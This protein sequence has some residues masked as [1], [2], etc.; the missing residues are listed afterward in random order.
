MIK[1]RKITSGQSMFEVVLALFIITMIII[2]VVILSTSSVSNALSSRR[3]TQAVKYTQEAI[4]W[5]R[6]EKIADISQFMVY[7]N[8]TSYC[9]NS[10]PP[11]FSNTGTCQSSELIESTFKRDLSFSK[12]TI[13]VSGENKVIVSA[14]VVTSWTDNDG[15]HEARSSTNFT[16]IRETE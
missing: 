11:N 1:S 2:A 16:D 7:A 10:N 14:T 13:L 8:T 15:Y 4:E 5:L 12:S 6:K 9:L 3:N